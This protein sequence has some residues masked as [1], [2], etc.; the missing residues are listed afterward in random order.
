[1]TIHLM[2]RTVKKNALQEAINKAQELVND[3]NA[4]EDDYTQGVAAL[5]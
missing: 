5:K 1:M 2:R 4:A 3:S